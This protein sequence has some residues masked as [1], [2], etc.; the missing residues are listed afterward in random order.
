MLSQKIFWHYPKRLHKKPK[1]DDIE[2]KE[3]NSSIHDNAS[4]IAKLNPNSTKAT[5]V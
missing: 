5:L 2:A 1:N 4:E 3:I